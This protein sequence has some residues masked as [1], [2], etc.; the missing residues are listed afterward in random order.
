MHVSIDVD[1]PI[2]VS[3]LSGQDKKV[4]EIFDSQILLFRYQG[5]IKAVNNIC[6]HMNMPIDAGQVTEDGS[7]LCPFHDSAFCVTTGEVRRWVGSVREGTPKALEDLMK[8]LKRSPLRVY[9]T[10]EVDGHIWIAH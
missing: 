5:N 7:I 6:P 9:E 2:V 4:I 8:G 3:R 10:D 1:A